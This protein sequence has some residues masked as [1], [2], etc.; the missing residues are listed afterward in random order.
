M[1][2]ALA[3]VLRHLRTVAAPAG[4]DADLLQQ[5]LARRDESACAAA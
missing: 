5:F 2:A 1:S 3:N 4:S